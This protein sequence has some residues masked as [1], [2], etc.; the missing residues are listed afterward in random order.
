[1]TV[2]DLSVVIPA[3]NEASRLDKTVRTVVDYLNRER[4]GAELIVVDDG[5]KDDTAEVAERGFA[6][7]GSVRT[8]LIR[9][10][11]NRGKGNAVHTG[12]L[13]ARAPIVLF[14]DAELSTPITETP[15]L[16]GPI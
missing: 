9:N 10:H 6:D 1:M 7:A 4:P 16:V 15:Q 2:P 14:S 5:S 11:P 12:L 8:R 3:F 13:T